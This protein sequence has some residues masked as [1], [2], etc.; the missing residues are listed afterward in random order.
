V[1]DELT[2]LRSVRSTTDGAPP[3]LV[4]AALQRARQ[5]FEAASSPAP[6]HARRIR[7]LRRYRTALVTAAAVVTAGALVATGV[8]VTH[9]LGPESAAAATLHDAARAATAAPDAPGAATRV[10]VRELALGY[11]TSDGEH[12]D[13]G[14]L[15]PTTTVT[16]IPRDVSGTW[17]RE[18][19]SEPATRIYGGR[20][21]RDAAQ[22]DYATSAHRDDPVRDRA[23]GGAFGNGE[24]GGTP[25]GTLTPADIA[26]LP[27]DADALVR[28][29]EAAPRAK[30]ATDAEHV[31]DTLADFLRT[32]LVPDDL[33]GAVFDALADLP[34]IVVTDDQASLDGRHGT[35]IGLTASGGTDRR[36][37]IVN[38]V[39]GDYLGERTLQ[40]E[41]LG[42]IPAGTVID[43]ASRPSER[44]STAWWPRRSCS[45]RSCPLHARGCGGSTS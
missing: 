5:R 24:L 39:T 33:R 19:W 14:Y 28:R 35:A 15:F 27:R 25:A 16:W 12:Y 8:G 3:E 20:A 38:R 40:T 26:T 45:R 23:A 37:V 42:S 41:R 22:R 36:E 31:F 32:G 17:T 6:V 13:E 21:A 4:D 29:V 43:S 30:G 1:P 18:S 44:A 9:L 7:P 2:L 10:T 34:G 11:A